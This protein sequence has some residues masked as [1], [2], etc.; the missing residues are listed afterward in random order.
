MLVSSLQKKKKSNLKSKH[1]LFSCWT[2]VLLFAS[3]P[4]SQIYEPIFL[5]W[6][7]FCWN[8]VPSG[9][10]LDGTLGC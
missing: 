2:E 1:V 10:D 9:L 7:G 3:P 6:F 4:E 5:I 8:S